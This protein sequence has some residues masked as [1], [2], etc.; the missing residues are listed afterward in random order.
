M[1]VGLDVSRQQLGPHI[2]WH[3][4][5]GGCWVGFIT[6]P[7]GFSDEVMPVAGLPAAARSGVDLFLGAPSFPDVLSCGAGDVVKGLLLPFSGL[8]D[9]LK[10]GVFPPLDRILGAEDVSGDGLFVPGL[11]VAL[12]TEPDGLGLLCLVVGRTGAPC[13]VSFCPSWLPPVGAGLLVG[14]P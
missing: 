12:L 6:V 2:I 9:L 8:I 10:L 4:T 3:S 14:T 11:G 13:P 1:V 5:T 7:F